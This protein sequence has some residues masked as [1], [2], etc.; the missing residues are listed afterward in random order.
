VF[1]ALEFRLPD[2][3]REGVGLVRM[4]L[5]AVEG[6]GEPE[7]VPASSLEGEPP[8]AEAEDLLQG[9]IG[10]PRLSIRPEPIPFAPRERRRPTRRPLDG[11]SLFGPES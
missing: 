11:P 9:P 8:A 4:T 6:R 1:S 10:R 5:A 7:L 2:L 3:A